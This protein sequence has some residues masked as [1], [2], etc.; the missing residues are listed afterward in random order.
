[1]QIQQA[2]IPDILVLTPKVFRDQR[3]SF[4]EIYNLRE[5]ESAGIRQSF[6][7]DNHSVS[8]RNVLR[9][10]HYQV[11]HPQGKLIRVVVGTIFDVAVDLRRSSP[12]FGRHMTIELSSD[13]RTMLWLPVGFAH[14]FLALSSTAEVLY[15][16]TDYYSPDA[17][18]TIR[19]DDPDLAIKWPVSASELILSDKDA[20]G[21]RFKDAEYL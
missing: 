20:N 19:W 7:Q 5:M 9:G 8:G 3:G 10:L 21:R 6:V 18:R 14:G 15:K 1:M 11:A 13:N 12:T 16:T 17:E 2:S 4:A